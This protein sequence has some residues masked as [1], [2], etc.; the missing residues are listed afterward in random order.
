MQCEL[1]PDAWFRFADVG[2][3]S[4]QNDARQKLG[5]YLGIASAEDLAGLVFVDNASGAVNAVLRSLLFTA[6]KD[7]AFA[8]RIFGIYSQD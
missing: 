4:I 3:K 2:M 1:N 7:G 8:P 6:T 5:A